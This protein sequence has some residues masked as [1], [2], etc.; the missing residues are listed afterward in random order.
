MLT[1]KP[2]VNI[3]VEQPLYMAMQDLANREGVSMSTI[4][5]NLIR[6]AIEL[7]EE[8][9]LATFADKQMKTFN[10]KASLSHEAVWK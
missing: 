6:E 3:I 9:A 8:V 10:R 1:K 5:R 7:R 2:R 4:A